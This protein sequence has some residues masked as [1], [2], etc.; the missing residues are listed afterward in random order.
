VLTDAEAALG[1]SVDNRPLTDDFEPAFSQRSPTLPALSSPVPLTN[2]DPSRHRSQGDESSA[3]SA[4]DDTV[5]RSGMPIERVS[6]EAHRDHPSAAE[7][8]DPDLGATSELSPATIIGIAEPFAQSATGP[9][10]AV[11]PDGL[12]PRPVGESTAELRS[13]L[14]AD[15]ENDDALFKLAIRLHRTGRTLEARATISRLAAVYEQRGQPA[16]AMRIRQMV[17][18]PTSP[19]STSPLLQDHSTVDA[20]IPLGTLAASGSPFN[21][22]MPL[23]DATGGLAAATTE[24]GAQTMTLGTLP[25]S[26][27][28]SLTAD[29]LSSGATAVL[30]RIPGNATSRLRQSRILGQGATR[31]LTGS[32]LTS[33]Q[34]AE[35]EAP[36]VALLLASELAFTVPLPGEEKLDP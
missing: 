4:L 15:P 25:T 28:S 7:T 27:L 30:P 8:T 26:E 24:L 13:Q 10:P 21:A 12:G 17:G 1:R 6:P 9:F 19:F 22:T 29:P 18:D 36:A 20:T 31:T 34:A 33:P 2:P 32:V 16:R 3:L 11:R 23:G 14:K 35:T 5:P